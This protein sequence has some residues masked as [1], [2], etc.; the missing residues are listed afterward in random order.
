MSF[1]VETRATYRERLQEVTHVDGTSRIQTLRRGQNPRFFELLFEFGKLSGLFCLL[2]T[3][4][5]I[6]GEPIVETLEDARNFLLK[7][8]VDGLIVGDYWIQRA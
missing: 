8:P 6:M 1:A 4:L 3:S 5:N 7:T 2:N